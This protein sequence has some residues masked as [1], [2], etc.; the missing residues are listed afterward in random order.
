MAGVAN[1]AAKTPA[2][3]LGAHRLA[4]AGHWHNGFAVPHHFRARSRQRA[5][6]AAAG[7][8]NAGAQSPARRFRHLLSRLFYAAEPFSV[9]AIA[10]HCRGHSGRRAGFAH[11]AGQCAHARQLPAPA[12]GLGHRPAHG[13]AGR[14]HHA[15][16]VRVVSA[17]CAAVGP[18]WQRQGQNRPEQRHDRGQYRRAGARRQYCLSRAVCGR[19]APALGHVLPRPGA[20]QAGRAKVDG[21]QLSQNARQPAGA[22]RANRPRSQPRSWLRSRHRALRGAAATASHAMA[23]DA[24]YCRRAT[25]PAR[26]LARFANGIHGMDQPPPH[27]RCAALPGQQPAQLPCRCIHSDP[28]SAPLSGLAARAE[29]TH[30]RAGAALSQRPQTGQQ[31]PRRTD[32]GRALRLAPRRLPLYPGTGPH[33][34]AR[35]RHFLV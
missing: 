9:F 5:D 31:H 26:R 23:A 33:G 24:G 19:S 32:T 11:C 25:H 16:A 8:Q 30:A 13:L 4:G 21:Q 7:A 18:A 6:F 35:G 14:A 17:L 12:Q 15:G 3:P 20:G 27:Y 10:A 29:S 22:T 28:L 2:H 34:R 1:Y